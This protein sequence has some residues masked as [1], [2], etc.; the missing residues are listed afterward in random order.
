MAVFIWQRFF[1]FPA[2]ITDATSLFIFDIIY[3]E[4]CKMFDESALV[5]V[6]QIKLPSPPPYT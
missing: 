3:L 4:F 6:L 1:Y 5:T 2:V